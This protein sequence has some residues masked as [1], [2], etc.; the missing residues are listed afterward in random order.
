[1]V[2]PIATLI[3]F[4]IRV[5]K[6]ILEVT[7]EIHYKCNLFPILNAVLNFFLMKRQLRLV[8]KCCL[9]PWNIIEQYEHQY[10]S[11]LSPLKNI[12]NVIK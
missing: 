4:V 1:M 9:H 6:L 12:L 3:V 2:L 10:K 11:M 5:H 8:S 7:K